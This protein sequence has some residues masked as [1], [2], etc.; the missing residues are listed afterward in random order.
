MSGNILI[1]DDEVSVLKLLKEFL[2]NDGYRVR[3]FNNTEL[4]LRSMQLDKPEL[5][6]LDMRMPIMSGLE[7]CQYIKTNTQLQDIPVIFISGATDVKDKLDAFQ[8]GGADYI[9][10]P[11]QKEEV[12]A[13]V[14][15][16]LT[17]YRNLQEIKRINEKLEQSKEEIKRLSASELNKA[18]LE[19]EKASQAKSEFLSSMSHELRT[20]LNAILGFAQLLKE[21]NLT[22]DQFDDVDEILTGGYHLLDLINQILDLCKIEAD[23]LKINLEKIDLQTMVENCLTMQK[24]IAKKN[25]I[26][27]ID[28]SCE[29]CKFQIIADK[30]CL[31]QVLLNL[32]SNAIKY[33]RVNGSVTLTTQ[34][35]SENILRINVIDT[36]YGLSTQQMN[37]LFQSFERLSAKYSNI[38]GSGIGLVI[39]KKLIEKMG[40]HIGVECV[41]NQGCC[42]WLEIPL[43]Q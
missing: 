30:L 31:K 1:L 35:M 2:I 23:K 5:I 12:L 43:A 39:S 34:K 27:L 4:A 6:V 7:V 38:E 9:V 19:A 25:N 26:T 17:L 16:H 41:E 21:E 10:K 42:F 20:P 40:H 24:L 36:G 37:K 18:K 32:I 29:E 3:P 28:K 15:T 11:F 14:K 13:R 8:A 22:E 33:N